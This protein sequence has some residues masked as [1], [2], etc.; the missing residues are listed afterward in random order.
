MPLRKKAPGVL[1]GMLIAVAASTAMVLGYPPDAMSAIT[2]TGAKLPRLSIVEEKVPGFIV[3]PKTRGGEKLYAALSSRDASELSMRAIASLKVYRSMSGGSHVLRLDKPVPLSAARSIAARLMRDSGMEMVEP[4]R[5]A[6]P[7]AVTPNDPL[8]RDGFQWHLMAPD[9]FNKGGVNLPD[10][11]EVTL[12][13]PSVVV[14][15][16]DNGILPHEDINP[17]AVLPGY[18]FITNFTD[19][20]RPRSKDGD[21]RDANSRDPGDYVSSEDFCFD[22]DAP[23]QNHSSWHGTHVAGTII[24]SMNNNIGITGIAPNAKLL[25]VRVLGTCGGVFS[26]IIDG[27]RWAA[28]IGDSSLPVN[29]TPASILNLSLGGASG[30]CSPALQSA[31]NDVVD[32]GVIIVAANGN[33]NAIGVAQPANCKGAIAVTAHS[34]DGDTTTYA[35][36]GFTT[37]ISAPGGGCGEGNFLK[38]QCTAAAS[39]GIVSTLNSG[40]T[41]PASDTYAGY[42]G[43]SMAA[44]HVAGVAAL[45]LSSNRSLV[46]AQT[47]SYLQSSVRPFPENSACALRLV[48]AG[49]CGSGLLDARQS[50]ATVAALPPYFT[51]IVPNSVV[52]P[53]AT[54]SLTGTAVAVA[55]RA[56]TAL[57]WSQRSGPPVALANASTQT[58]SFTAPASGVL[59]FDLTA[60]DSTGKASAA[61]VTFRVNSPPVVVPLPEQSTLVGEPLTFALTATDIDGDRIFFTPLS[62]PDGASLSADGVVSWPSASPTGKYA[63]TYIVS[64]NDS[65]TEGSVSIAVNDP[66]PS[67]GGGSLDAYSL[68]LLA[69]ATAGLRIRRTRRQR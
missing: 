12:G 67:G 20:T 46:P 3:K 8:Y 54:V 2:E 32:Q 6:R 29:S 42:V 34:I 26:D 24:A 35:N 10:A 45:M 62:L 11:W 60:T 17:L 56:V 64:D 30:T 61:T 69:I 52:A 49:R 15:V 13:A 9:N 25:P 44:P 16:L 22:E 57:E 21:G 51:A 59:S 39:Q 43:T 33:E 1:S 19:V 14:A 48:Y 28:G 38:N 58:A 65:S 5:I 31:V 36:I 7:F 40:K 18:D 55:G 37:T 66:P 68:A 41:R 23:D 27:M 47:M 53:G 50:L 63:L 4:D